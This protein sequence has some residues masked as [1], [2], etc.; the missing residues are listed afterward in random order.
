MIPACTST[1]LNRLRNPPRG[2]HIWP[3]SR[4]RRRSLREA[5]A[6]PGLTPLRDSHRS[7]A[8]GPARHRPSG[9]HTQG[10]S[11]CNYGTVRPPSTAQAHAAPH[12]RSAPASLAPVPLSEA[13]EPTGDR[14]CASQF[15]ACGGLTAP[16][17]LPRF[18]PARERRR[19]LPS[20]IPLPWRAGT[21]RQPLS[22]RAAARHAGSCSPK[23]ERP[24]L[25]SRELATR[26]EQTGPA[27]RR[28]PPQTGASCGPSTHRQGP[29]SRQ[30]SVRTLSW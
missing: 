9:P 21:A 29:G 23:S 2:H 17:S 3:C 6:A 26:G 16:A 4:Q 5:A 18:R 15:H 30:H 13:E 22:C 28:A 25:R 1:T 10:P 19:E 11:R 27:G 24:V 12:P 8:R 14:L 7:A 20:H